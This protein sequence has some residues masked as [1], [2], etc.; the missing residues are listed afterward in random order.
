MP[1]E[2]ILANLRSILLDVC[3]HR[4]ADMGTCK[5]RKKKEKQQLPMNSKCVQLLLQT[6]DVIIPGWNWAFGEESGLS[7][8]ASSQVLPGFDVPPWFGSRSS[9][10]TAVLWDSSSLR[11]PLLQQ[12]QR[13]DTAEK[14][15]QMNALRCASRINGYSSDSTLT[16]VFKKRANG[17]SL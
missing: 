10:Q 8:C 3:S 1:K 5:K 13:L 7:A 12:L 4:P 2:H 6:L 14:A 16:G 15:L 11:S 9:S 17:V